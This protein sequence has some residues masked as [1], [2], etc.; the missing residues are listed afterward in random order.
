MIR[1]PHKL[2]FSSFVHVWICKKKLLWS[3]NQTDGN[4]KGAFSSFIHRI[5]NSTLLLPLPI[6]SSLVRRSTDAVWIGMIDL[7]GTFLI[8]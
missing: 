5:E 6:Y 7:K 4:L 8:Y 1:F 2:T 3:G